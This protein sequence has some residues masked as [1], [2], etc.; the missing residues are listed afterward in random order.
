MPLGTG[1]LVTHVEPGTPREQLDLGMLR[2]LAANRV[3]VLDTASAYA[4]DLASDQLDL[5]PA[6]RPIGNRQVGGE[7]LNRQGHLVGDWWRFDGGGPERGLDQSLGLLGLQRM[8][9]HLGLLSHP[10]HL[11]RQ[12]PSRRASDGGAASPRPT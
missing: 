12:L 10:H 8:H 7:A 4:S 2:G 1:W 11:R 3:P 5:P 6:R 9:E